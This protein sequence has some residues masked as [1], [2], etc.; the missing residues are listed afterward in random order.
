MILGSYEITGYE[1]HVD[2]WMPFYGSYGLHDA[3]WRGSFGGD[4]YTYAGSHGCVNLPYSFAQKLYNAIDYWTP[5]LV[6]REGDDYAAEERAN[7]EIVDEA[8][9]YEARGPEEYD[10][11]S[12]I[13]GPFSQDSPADSYAS[14]S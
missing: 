9:E 14:Q 3:K 6:V 2:Y 8:D 4:I 10:V 11:M 1:S 7:L 12:D 13:T 5:V